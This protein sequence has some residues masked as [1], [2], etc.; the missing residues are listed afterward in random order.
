MLAFS[1]GTS[2]LQSAISFFHNSP[3]RD[4]PRSIYSTP[5][6]VAF[7]FARK[8]PEDHESFGGLTIPFS[9]RTAS[10]IEVRLPRFMHISLKL[11]GGEAYRGAVLAQAFLHH[12]ERPRRGERQVPPA[13]NSTLRRGRDTGGG[14]AVATAVA[15]AQHA[16]L[17][18]VGGGASGTGAGAVSQ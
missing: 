6:M 5:G 11:A 2:F 18:G 9:A 12:P 15:G 1:L 7:G 3:M 14:A 10:I 16:G 4:L 13:N 17:P 8:I